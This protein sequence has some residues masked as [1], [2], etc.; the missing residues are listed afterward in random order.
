MSKEIV[1]LITNFDTTGTHSYAVTSR[2]NCK[3]EIDKMVFDL[4]I[5][6]GDEIKIGQVVG[7][8]L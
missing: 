5:E 2:E 4:V 3:D 6:H 1:V 8:I 7:Y